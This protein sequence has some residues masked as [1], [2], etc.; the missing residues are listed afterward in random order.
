VRIGQKLKTSS[1]EVLGELSE[2]PGGS[3]GVQYIMSEIAVDGD[4]SPSA[5]DG[6]RYLTE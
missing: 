3:E 5:P 1:Q 2:S 6:G 4:P